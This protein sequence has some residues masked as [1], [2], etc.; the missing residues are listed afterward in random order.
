MPILIEHGHSGGLGAAVAES[1]AEQP[2]REAILH[3]FSAPDEFL[4]ITADQ[5]EAREHFGLTAEA[6]SRSLLD[7]LSTMKVGEAVA[8]RAK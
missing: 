4:H 2:G 6:I 3:R 5:R 8:D 7:V 1:Y